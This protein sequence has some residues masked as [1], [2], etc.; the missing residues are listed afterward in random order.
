MP[1][2][3]TISST[4]RPF[5]VAA[6][7]FWKVLLIHAEASADVLAL[8][9]GQQL[10]GAGLFQDHLPVVLGQ[11]GKDANDQLARWGGR[12]D[13]QIQRLEDDAPL[14]EATDQ[15]DQVVAAPAQ[16]GETG[17]HYGIT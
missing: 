16:A 8:G 12:V 2:R 9:F 1:V 5:C 10:A 3:L 14:G 17:N 11:G 4:E 15:A 13:A 6:L 7:T